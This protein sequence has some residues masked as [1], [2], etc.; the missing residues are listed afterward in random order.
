MFAGLLGQMGCKDVKVLYNK[1]SKLQD[2]TI[3]QEAE[4]EFVPPPGPP[5]VNLFE[6]TTKKD[7]VWIMVHVA[8]DEGMVGENLKS[9]AYSLKV[10]RGKPEPVK[11]PPDVQ[12]LLDQ[13]CRA[14]EASD[15]AKIMANYS[16]QFLNDGR[17]KAAEEQ[18]YRY[19]PFSPIVVGVA[20]NE[21]TVTVF[22]PHGD[23]AYLAGFV[24]YTL[25]AGPPGD[26]PF[27]IPQ[28]IKED[29][30]WKWYGNQK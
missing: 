28:I 30:Q 27:P 12:A 13:H 19:A 9:V 25:K 8:H 2:G 5:K 7:G 20:S 24:G 29:G 1:P 21:I 22:E 6:L 18:W 17:K 26:T 23:K 11:V 3:A 15:V 10:P 14:V 16:D 4:I